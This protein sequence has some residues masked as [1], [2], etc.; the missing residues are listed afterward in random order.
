MTP[1]KSDTDE[2]AKPTPTLIFLN[3]RPTYGETKTDANENIN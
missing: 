1:T 2:T 3:D